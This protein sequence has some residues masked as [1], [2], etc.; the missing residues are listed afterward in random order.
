M[1][2]EMRCA[3]CKKGSP[4]KLADKNKWDSGQGA[5]GNQAESQEQATE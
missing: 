3:T 2:A 5:D 1:N 4:C